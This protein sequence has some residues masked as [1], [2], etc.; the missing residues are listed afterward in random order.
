M[1]SNPISRA[2]FGTW[3][4]NYKGVMTITEL[5]EISEG[6]FKPLTLRI[7]KICMFPKTEHVNEIQQFPR[8]NDK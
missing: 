7:R 6:H 2:L 3:L 4:V 5:Y 8:N 1:P